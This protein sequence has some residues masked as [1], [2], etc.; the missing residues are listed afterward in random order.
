MNLSRSLFPVGA[1]LVIGGVAMRA[2]LDRHRFYNTQDWEFR[3]LETIFLPSLLLGTV[4]APIGSAFDRRRLVAK[5]LKLRY[6]LCLLSSGVAFV[7][8]AA[9]GNVH[10]W[11][12]TFFSDGGRSHMWRDLRVPLKRQLSKHCHITQNAARQGF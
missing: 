10:G 3:L 9:F 5:Q 4:L 2:E 12:F 7:L 1:I 8:L 11:T 6:V